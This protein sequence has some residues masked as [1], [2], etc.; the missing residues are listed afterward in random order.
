[1]GPG[2]FRRLQNDCDLTSSGR[3]GSI[4]TR[5]RHTVRGRQLPVRESLGSVA[6]T[7]T[8]LV[9]LAFAQPERVV[10]QI[11]DSARAPRP[12]PTGASR[13]RKAAPLRSAARDSL[14]P[15]LSPGRAF[16]YSFALPGVGQSKL[17]RHAA[18]AIYVTVEAMSVAMVAKS[19]NE[20]RIAKA[21]AHDVTVNSYQ[22]DPVTG[23]PRVDAA[24]NYVNADTVRNRYAGQR[25]KARRTQVED[26]FAALV[27]NHLFAGADAFVSA[28]LWDL[29]AQVSLRATP[30]G[31]G[32]GLTITP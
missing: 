25:V 10:A 24:G 4:P 1:M 2:G 32:V 5:S 6:W 29:P 28:Q 3:V 13:A 12:D 17:R 15:P 23:A 14:Q 26:W 9:I 7:M 31:Y 30:Y 21:H 8:A 19:A 20:L 11:P 27:F 18:G 16:L 22:T